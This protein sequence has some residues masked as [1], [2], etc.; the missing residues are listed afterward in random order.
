MYFI[1]GA[2]TLISARQ[3]GSLCALCMILMSGIKVDGRFL[4]AYG[5]IKCFMSLHEICERTT[6]DLHLLALVI[7]A[8]SIDK[9][10][11]VGMEASV[12]GKRWSERFLH[13]VWITQHPIRVRFTFSSYQCLLDIPCSRHT[14][15]V[16]E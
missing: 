1:L 6:R 5:P 14:Q 13:I 9:P 15:N 16:A 12:V 10:F 3:G 2:F 8:V 7:A 4:P 11:R